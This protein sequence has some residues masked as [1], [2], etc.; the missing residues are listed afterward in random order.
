MKAS[1]DNCHLIMNCTEATSAKIDGF[2]I[3]SRKTEV[4]QEI[5]IDH[6]LEF[7][8]DV[9]YLCKKVGQ[10]LNAL[11]RIAPFMNE[12]SRNHLLNPW[13]YVKCME[14]YISMLNRSLRYGTEFISFLAPKTWEILP[15]EIKDLD[16]LQIFRAK[17]EVY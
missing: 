3:D 15:N 9:N 4:L 8:D 11:D 1:S 7:D 16:T 14:Y 5:T 17:I 6:E 10:K 12:L 2:P 13:R